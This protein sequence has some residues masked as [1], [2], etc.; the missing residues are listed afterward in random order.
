MSPLIDELKKAQKIVCKTCGETDYGKC[1]E[2]QFHKTMNK[3]VNEPKFIK[4]ED[5]RTLLSFLRKPPRN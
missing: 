3:I 4:E 5:W 1:K 2:C